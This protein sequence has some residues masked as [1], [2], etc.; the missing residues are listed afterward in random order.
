MRSESSSQ[1]W[2]AVR[3]IVL[4]DA[5][6]SR[7]HEERITVWRAQ[8][9]EQAVERAE[10]EAREYTRSLRGASFAGLAQA[11]ASPRRMR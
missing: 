3:C 8:S 7:L 9:F 4:F 5:E 10:C 2:Y 11:S 1:S 6:E